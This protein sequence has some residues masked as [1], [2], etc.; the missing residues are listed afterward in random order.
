[1]KRGLSAIAEHLVNIVIRSTLFDKLVAHGIS[2][3]IL[4]FI[5]NV[6]DNRTRQTLVGTS[7]ST[8]AQSSGIDQRSGT[9]AKWCWG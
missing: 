9:N 3:S 6:L 5:V 8:V 2:G 7:L 1:M 4:H